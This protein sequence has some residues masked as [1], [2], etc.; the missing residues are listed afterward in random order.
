MDVRKQINYKK[1]CTIKIW[2]WNYKSNENNYQSDNKQIHFK[3]LQNNERIALLTWNIPDFLNGTELV[4]QFMVN[5]YRVLKML[6]KINYS[7]NFVA[8]RLNSDL[9]EIIM[10]ENDVR[11]F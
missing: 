2:Y 6:P 5:K 9:V 3:I 10:G 8:D 11:E 1:P 7:N 4:N